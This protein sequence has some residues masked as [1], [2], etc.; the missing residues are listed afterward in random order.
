[1]LSEIS[2]RKEKSRSKKFALSYFK[3][4]FWTALREQIENPLGK[5]FPEA[6][7]K[8]LNNTK[9]NLQE[10]KEFWEHRIVIN[11]QKNIFHLTSKERRIRL[12]AQLSIHDLLNIADNIQ[13]KHAESFYAESAKKHVN[14][15]E[16]LQTIAHLLNV[17][18]KKACDH[19]T[20]QQRALTQKKKYVL[21]FVKDACT[22]FGNVASVSP[23]DVTAAY[24]TLKEYAKDEGLHPLSTDRTILT[25]TTYTG[26]ER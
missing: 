15:V 20:S 5:A 13:N 21:V 19:L 22:T 16:S 12:D 25:S 14:M 17:N 18:Q 7:Q 8:V 23:G 1:M 10:M 9:I 26:S 11:P 24:N 3:L 4:L 2:K 6:E